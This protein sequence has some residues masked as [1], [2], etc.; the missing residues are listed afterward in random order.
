MLA[1]NVAHYTQIACTGVLKLFPILTKN[2]NNG[3]C[4]NIII[5]NLDPLID[6]L[7]LQILI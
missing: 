6:I 1:R 5:Y 2:G 4:R 3:F 7:I